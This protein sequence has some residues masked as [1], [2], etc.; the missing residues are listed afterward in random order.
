LQPARQHLEEE[1]TLTRL[2]FRRWLSRLKRKL[3]LLLF[4]P[5]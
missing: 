5:L 3:M 4:L 1:M 2:K